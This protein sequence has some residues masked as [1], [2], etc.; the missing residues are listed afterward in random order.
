MNNAEFHISSTQ[1]EDV[2]TDWD[3]LTEEEPKAVIDEEFLDPENAHNGSHF[4]TPE[5]NVEY[6]R[7]WKTNMIAAVKYLRDK[8]AEHVDRNFI[9][10]FKCVHWM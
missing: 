3:I 10:G 5:E 6:E 9:Q 4:M 8:W 2:S 7:L 1:N